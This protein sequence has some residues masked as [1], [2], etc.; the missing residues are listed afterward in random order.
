MKNK[1]TANRIRLGIFVSVA[2]ALFIIVIYFIGDGQHM[3]SKTIHL[4]GTF[5]NLGGL[6]VGN[7]VRFTGIN[8]GTIDQVEI[9]TDTTARVDM[10]IEKKVQK[11]IKQD[12]IAT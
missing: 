10:T 5:K 8:V 11:F 2:I 1:E 7:N 12:A 9:I 6:E 4:N 3:F